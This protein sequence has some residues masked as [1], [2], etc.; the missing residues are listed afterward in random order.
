MKRAE[1]QMA[2]DNKVAG[3]PAGV[4]GRA[5]AIAGGLHRGDDAITS[6]RQ[7]SKNAARVLVEAQSFLH[8]ESPDVVV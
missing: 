8:L 3:D 7:C 6:R 1:I 4:I 5:R 2:W